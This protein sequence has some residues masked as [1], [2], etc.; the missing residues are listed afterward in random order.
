MHLLGF[1]FFNNADS[2]YWVEHCG[3][4]RSGQS[5]VPAS[6]SRG[7]WNSQACPGPRQRPS[8]PRPLP[9]GLPPTHTPPGQA[10]LEPPGGGHTGPRAAASDLRLL[11]GDSAFSKGQPSA[12]TWSSECH[13]S[14]TV[15]FLIWSI[16]VEYLASGD[17]AAVMFA[18]CGELFQVISSL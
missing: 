8:Q 17:L 9:A 5:R 1:L 3:E 10:P 4:L 15:S 6:V 14:L 13:A 11:H 7:T 12:A 18:S 16:P 2:I